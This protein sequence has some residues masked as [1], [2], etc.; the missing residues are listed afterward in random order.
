MNETKGKLQCQIALQILASLQAQG[1]LT[2]GEVE[3]ISTLTK[4]HYATENVWEL[5]KFDALPR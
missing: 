5:S 3:K 2:Q 1:L 4:A